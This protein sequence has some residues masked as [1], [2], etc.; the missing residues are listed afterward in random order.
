MVIAKSIYYNVRPVLSR[1]AFIN[2]IIGGRGT[3]KTFNCKKFCIEDYIKHK[4]QFFYVRRYNTEVDLALT[5]FFEQLQHEGYFE[6]HEFSIKKEKKHLTKFLMDGEVIG[7]ACALSTSPIIKSASF[8]DVYNLIFDEA[9]IPRGSS[10]HYLKN[11]II[12]FLELLESVFRLRD[13]R[14]MILSNAITVAN[15]YYDYWDIVPKVGKQFEIY[16]NGDICLEQVMNQ[17]FIEAKKKTAV[18]RLIAGTKYGDYAISNKMLQDDGAFIAFK[19]PKAKPVGVIKV[20]GVTYGLWGYHKTGCYY[21][22]GYYN[23]TCRHILALKAGDHT[24]TTTLTGS[25]DM[26]L[27]RLKN[28]FENACLYFESEKCKKRILSCIMPSIWQ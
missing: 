14:V 25:G 4:R 2:L 26:L 21:V 15:P 12:L 3:G 22:S 24:E 13:G 28:A 11:E 19:P 27:I 6:D 17:D 5:G 1:N 20:D 7:F 9:L 18:G 10:Y 23:P 16:H 8:P